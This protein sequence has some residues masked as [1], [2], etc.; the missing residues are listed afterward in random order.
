MEQRGQAADAVRRQLAAMGAAR[1]EVGVKRADGRLL[2]LALTAGGVRGRMA[3]LARENERGADVFIRP[4]GNTGLVLLDDLD[5][6]ALARMEADGLA[7]AVV[8]ETS[9]GN[10]Q[11]WV[12]V[13]AE[14]IAPALATAAAKE[15]AA[16]YG[17]DPNSAAWRH[18][19]R[20]AGFENR[21]PRHRRADG[22]YPLVALRAATGE[23]A[24][25]GDD[26]LD[27]ARARLAATPPASR[28][29][30]RAVPIGRHEGG[31]I[32][33]LGQLYRGEVAR[34]VR[35]YPATDLSR[36]DWMIVLSLARAFQDATAEELA[37][38]MVEGS[39]GLTERKRGHVS[40]YVA[41]TVG[42]ALVLAG[43]GRDV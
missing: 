30:A 37:R 22:S 38:A 17:G 36:L 39:P 28:V 33:P 27:A 43:R 10:H 24:P 20:L 14:P 4:E 11:A 13:A 1:Y 15:L 40:D 42:K 23:V 5:G 35:R 9:P 32:S 12:R 8:V 34:L 26:L 31:P 6:A 25:A 18:Y 16:R 2:P 29:R 41:R 7:P 3:W 21:K 19:G